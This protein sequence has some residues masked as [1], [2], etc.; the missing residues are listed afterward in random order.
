MSPRFSEKE[1]IVN[2][3]Y[4]LQRAVWHNGGCVSL[5][6]V[7][8]QQVKWLVASVGSPP[9]RQAASTLAASF[10]WKIHPKIKKNFW[11]I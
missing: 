10:F 2:G 9:L 7:T 1:K 6:S 8:K 4:C 5:D 11:K 3:I